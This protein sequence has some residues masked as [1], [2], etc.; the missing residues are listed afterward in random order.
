[1]FHIF[2]FIIL[3]KYFTQQIYVTI[4]K[5]QKVHKSVQV[6]NVNNFS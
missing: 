4:K 1:M 3:V 2:T 5:I 6:E